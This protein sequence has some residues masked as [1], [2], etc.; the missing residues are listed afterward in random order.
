M[1]TPIHA[2]PQTL[3]ILKALHSQSLLQESSLPPLPPRCTPAFNEIMSDKFIALEQDKA[4]FVYNLLRSMNAKN[5][6]EAGTSFGVSTIYLALAVSQNVERSGGSGNGS[7]RVVATENEP[8]KAEKARENWS[9]AIGGEG[10]GEGVEGVID[11]RVGDLLETLKGDLGVVDFLLLDIWTPL[12]LP[13]LKLVQPSL[14][15]GAVIIADNTVSS[16]EDYTAL[17]E[18]VE[19]PENGFRRMLLPFKGGLDMI[20]YE[21]RA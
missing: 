14:R 4:C 2:P 12:A 10:E 6:I 7:G 16:Y 18:Y 11:L 19:N 9:L 17:R 8:G 1:S 13:T 20:I 3:A 15:S 21:P 5:V